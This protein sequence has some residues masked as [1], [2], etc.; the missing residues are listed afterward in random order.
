ME[1][2]PPLDVV[3]CEEPLWISSHR[4]PPATTRDAYLLHRV[5]AAA[6]LHHKHGHRVPEGQQ[7][8]GWSHR[9]RVRLACKGGAGGRVRRRPRLRKAAAT[10]SRSALPSFNAVTNHQHSGLP[11]PYKQTHLR[12]TQAPAWAQSNGGVRRQ[13]LNAQGA[14]DGMTQSQRRQAPHGTTESHKRH[15]HA[16]RPRRDTAPARRRPPPSRARRGL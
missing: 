9:G 6:R 15:R 3:H 4:A 2:L 11:D 12:T 10:A 16:H 13:S 1:R 14:I 5:E 8:R 7:G